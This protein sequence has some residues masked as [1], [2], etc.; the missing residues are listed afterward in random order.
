MPIFHAQRLFYCIFL[1][2]LAGFLAVPASAWDGNDAYM[3]E[4]ANRE[5]SGQVHGAQ[6][7]S[8]LE[9]LW[10]PAHHGDPNTLHLRLSGCVLNLPSE[11]SSGRVGFLAGIFKLGMPEEV[12]VDLQESSMLCW[13]G[14]KWGPIVNCALDSAEEAAI[15]EA[16]GR[17]VLSTPG[18]ASYDTRQITDAYVRL[19][20][21]DIFTVEPS[22]G[23]YS[24]SDGRDVD[25]V[26]LYWLEPGADDGTPLVNLETPS[27]SGVE[28][29]PIEIIVPFDE[30]SGGE[31]NFYIG[32]LEAVSLEPASGGRAEI[33][34]SYRAWE[35]RI[36]LTGAEST[37]EEPAGDEARSPR[38]GPGSIPGAPREPDRSVRDGDGDRSDGFPG[39]RRERRPTPG[40]GGEPGGPPGSSTEGMVWI[41]GG[42][43]LIG[44]SMSD[45]DAK[46]DEQP[47]KLVVLEG[48][49]IDIFPVTNE[50]Y[51]E[52]VGQTG[53]V[54]GGDWQS[55]FV[56]GQERYPARGMTYYD[57][58]AYADWAGKRLP[59][60]EEW[61]AAA[62]GTDGRRYPWG[63]EWIP[64]N[65]A[66]EDYAPV[67]AHPGNIS[68]FGVREM[69]GNVWEWT[70]SYFGAYSDA[71]AHS[72]T[73]LVL[74]GGSVN[75]SPPLCRTTERGADPRNM[76]NASYGFRCVMDASAATDQPLTLIESRREEE[77]VTEEEEE[78]E[79]EERQP[80]YEPIR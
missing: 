43:Y 13:N 14:I 1:P 79:K 73:L 38:E 3:E 53:Y 64:E 2:L 49:Y 35:G 34:Y 20:A 26:D 15:A 24:T 52:F 48:F 4:I 18:A 9:L 42:S 10:E 67:D 17:G 47:Q 68:P 70:Q 21:P 77:R 45:P 74:R 32:Y 57:A 65:A 59:T 28:V 39:V 27:H 36:R 80:R 72:L 37:P 25:T 61:E 75:C 23:F 44:A 62:R 63:N 31:C 30:V 19:H 51:W 16:I 66:T 76:G 33:V 8:E 11:F 60:E 5:F 46:I 69:S 54:T 58:V 56:P 50:D 22:Q 29:L 6:V 12:S 41:P 40:V 71:S 55:Y 78:D 7:R